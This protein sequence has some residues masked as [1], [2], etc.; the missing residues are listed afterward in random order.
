MFVRRYNRVS[1]FDQLRREISGLLDE[2]DPLGVRGA[3]FGSPSFPA[4]NVWEGGDC[5]YA[6][7]EIP[8]VAQDNIEILVVGNELTI[9]GRRGAPDDKEVSYH[10]RERGTGEFS[11]TLTLPVEI[12]ADAVEATLKDG[13]LTLKLPKAD[14][15]RPRRIT[16]K[17]S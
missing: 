5:L 1:P 9:K 10:R 12:K 13:V 2:F 15:A 8:G 6:E 17:A 16:V 4:I 11:R 14:E 3:L 7:A